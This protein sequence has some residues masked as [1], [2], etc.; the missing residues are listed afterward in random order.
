[1]TI[2]LFPFKLAWDLA[3]F[4]LQTTGRLMAILF[5]VVLMIVGVVISLTIIGMIIGIP[6][7]LFGFALVI[8]G[9]F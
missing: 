6:L 8:R 4:I 3:A 1:M 9:L 2:L 7:L 5:G